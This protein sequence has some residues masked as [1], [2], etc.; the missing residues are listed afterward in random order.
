MLRAAVRL[1]GTAFVPCTRVGGL[2]DRARLSTKIATAFPRYPTREDAASQPRHIYEMDSA[3]LL[4]MATYGD[5]G[6]RRE[7]LIRE[8][9]H[10]DQL[11]W[12]PASVLVDEMAVVEI[13]G[14]VAQKLSEAVG[15]GS[16][17]FGLGALP[18]V[19]HL[20]TALW[21][22]ERFVTTDVPA[23]RDLET[24]LEVG[25]WTWNWMEPPIGTLSFVFL[26]FQFARGRGIINPVEAF[27]MRRRQRRLLAT[28]PGYAPLI[29][30]QWAESLSPGQDYSPLKAGFCTRAQD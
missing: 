2:R 3:T 27:H 4:L 12:L 22:N 15:V 23:A 30:M 16:I 29:L 8:I 28:Y 11:E 6:A 17:I 21:F 7:R 26:A 1:R 9:M 20:D 24:W 25:Q 14:H 10:V 13:K 18:M 19:F 5:A